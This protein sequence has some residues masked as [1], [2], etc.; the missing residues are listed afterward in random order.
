MDTARQ[1][2]ELV[3]VGTADLP[4]VNVLLQELSV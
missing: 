3:K 4:I 1:F 2:I